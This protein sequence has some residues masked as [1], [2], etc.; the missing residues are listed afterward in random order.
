MRSPTTAKSFIRPKCATAQAPGF[1]SGP[2]ALARIG[3]AFDEAIKTPTQKGQEFN[4]S[5]VRSCRGARFS[6]RPWFTRAHGQ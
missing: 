4:D 5:A 1:Q 3:R 6:V 2:S